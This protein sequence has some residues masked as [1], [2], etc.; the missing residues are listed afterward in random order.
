[1]LYQTAGFAMAAQAAKGTAATSNFIRGRMTNSQLTPMLDELDTAGEHTGTHQRSTAVQSTPIRA[2]YMA[3]INFGFRLYPELIGYALIGVGFKVATT[4]DSPVVGANTH[5]FT[6]ADAEAEGWV[7]F[8]QALGED[9]ARYER[10]VT[11]AR[12]SSLAIAASRTGITVT[13]NAMG[14]AEADSAGSETVVA[15]A[16]AMLSQSNGS[17]TLTSSNL[18]ALTLG[19]PRSHTLTIDNPLDDQEQD[20]HSF[21]RA[22]FSPTGK[23]ISGTMEGLVFSENIYK[24]FIYG[25]TAGVTPAIVIPKA[26]IAYAFNSPAMITGTT[27]YSMSTA[28]A[29]ALVTMDPFDITGGGHITYNLKYRMQDALATDPIT[30]TLVNGIASYAG[31]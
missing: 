21:S 20:L 7:S 30:I 25:S 17:F 29:V 23:T 12:V 15:D 31:S 16:D 6:L 2:G 28:I 13:G 1:M 14:I 26:A 10:K 9:T 3:D 22:T 8:M 24:E 18:T 27:P 11:D 5:V 19:T 4:T